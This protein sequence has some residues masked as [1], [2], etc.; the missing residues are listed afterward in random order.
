MQNLYEVHVKFNNT[1][2]CGLVEPVTILT[3]IT[4]LTR[5]LALL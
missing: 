1:V 2:A 4:K 3:M 5:V